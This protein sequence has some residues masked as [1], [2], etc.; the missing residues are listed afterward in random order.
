MAEKSLRQALQIAQ[1]DPTVLFRSWI[2]T[3]LI[4]L[5]LAAVFVPLILRARGKDLAV[6]STDED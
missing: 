6:F 1:G 5:A 2:S 3:A 4:A